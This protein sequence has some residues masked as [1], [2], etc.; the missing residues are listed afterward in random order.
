M[1]GMRV[2]PLAVACLVLWLSPCEVPHFFLSPASEPVGPAREVAPPPRLGMQIPWFIGVVTTVG[3][4]SITVQGFSF[5]IAGEFRT[6]L[7]LD[8]R[9]ILYTTTT[10]TNQPLLVTR[11]GQQIPAVRVVGTREVVIFTTPDGRSTVFRRS[12]EPLRS[13]D[14]TDG[15]ASGGYETDAR[16]WDTYPLSE[17]RVGDE[18]RLRICQFPK[19]YNVCCGISIERRPGGRVP[20]APG[21]DPDTR[22]KHHEWMQAEQDWEEKGIP[23]PYKYHQ[24]GPWPQLAPPPREVKPAKP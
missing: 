2:I 6:K 24:G 21:E 18:V 8:G 23:L 14:V 9:L 1:I 16:P 20:P 4:D 12:D 17:V 11:A 22:I 5:F 10:S 13:F 15:L 7:G 19:K 3:R